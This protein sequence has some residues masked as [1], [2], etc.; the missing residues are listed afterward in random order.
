MKATLKNSKYLS[1]YSYELLDFKSQESKR[2]LVQLFEIY[3]LPYNCEFRHALLVLEFST[4][5][6]GLRNVALEKCQQL[7]S[8][9][10]DFQAIAVHNSEEKILINNADEEFIDRIKRYV[11]YILPDSSGINR[12]E[13][14]NELNKLV[15]IF[16]QRS[17]KNF[18]LL[19]E[20]F[21]LLPEECR[22]PYLKQRVYEQALMRFREGKIDEIEVV[23]S[24][25]C[26]YF[27][28]SKLKI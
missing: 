28:R 16:Y 13:I 27:I 22:L 5:N 15:N 19:A 3:G 17:G 11:H 20:V 12:K 26:F 9:E 2:P 6:R 8:C 21:A 14:I 1:I 18:S 10:D 7:A 23:L 4:I 24:S 25:P